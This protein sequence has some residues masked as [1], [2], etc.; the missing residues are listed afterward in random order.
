[1]VVRV[2][3]H[4][5]IEEL[6]LTTVLLQLLDQEHMMDIVTRQSIGICDEHLVERSQGRPVAEAVKAGPF[7]R[8]AAVAVIAKDV[9]LGELPAL[10]LDVP[11][12]PLDLLIDGLCL[13]LAL[14]RNTHIDCNSHR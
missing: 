4:R 1:L 2:L 8:G 11:P 14:C 7:E 5:P 10:S 6:D 9:L 3:G 12:Q 13:C